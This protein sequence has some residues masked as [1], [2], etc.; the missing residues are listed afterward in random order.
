VRSDK[1]EYTAD[2]L[3]AIDSAIAAGGEK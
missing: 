2:Y 3:N 1:Y